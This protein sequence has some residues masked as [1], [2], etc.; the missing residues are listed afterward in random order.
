MRGGRN[1]AAAI[2]GEIVAAGGNAE[3]N[4]LS[5]GQDGVQ[6]EAAGPRLPLSRVLV[7]ADAGDHLPGVARVAAAE[8]GGGLEAAPQG[9]LVGSGSGGPDDIGRAPARLGIGW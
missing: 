3:M 5:V 6:A 7:V 9:R 8:G 4:A 1:R 2:L